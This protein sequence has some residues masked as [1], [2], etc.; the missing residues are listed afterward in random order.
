M[1]ANLSP[2]FTLTPVIGSGLISA[3][4]TNL[5]GT[6][7]IV[8]I[9][10]GGTDGT[11]ITRITIK[12]LQTTTAGIV[13]LFIDDGSNVRL[14]KEIAVE[15][16]TISASVPSFYYELLLEQEEALV[17]PAT[18]ELQASTHNAETF[19]VMAEGGNY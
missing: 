17:L 7:T 4:N 18:Y 11:R 5:D 12:A 1:T 10:T 2:I 19:V 3:A 6:G 13:R 9:I 15:A 8:S 14:W 16:I